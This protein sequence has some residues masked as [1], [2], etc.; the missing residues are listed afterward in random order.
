MTLVEL[1]NKAN[2]AY[3][4][5]MLNLYYDEET[6]EA[7]QYSGGDELAHWI[8]VELR[9]TFDSE[10]SEHDQLAEAVRVMANAVRDVQG[11]LDVL[12]KQ[13]EE[14][15]EH[16]D[17]DEETQLIEDMERELRPGATAPAAGHCPE[18]GSYDVAYREATDD[19][20]CK[21]CGTVFTPQ[22]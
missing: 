18:C 5:Q 4:D 7:V 2:E 22:L 3:P 14:V 17:I 21:D 13:L 1:L 15:D 20:E 8:V 6:G 12:E 11:V 16:L 10:A 19:Y 9:E